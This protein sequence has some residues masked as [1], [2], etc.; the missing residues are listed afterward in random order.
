MSKALSE[1]TPLPPH[2][3]LWSAQRGALR[4]TAV[5]LRDGSLCLYSPVLGLGD[6]A[7][8]SLDALG[9][10]SVLLA[11]NHYH[12][13][14]L[15]EYAQVFPDA[16]LICSERA[17][18]RLEKQTGL[19]FASLSNLVPLLPDDCELVEPDGL[20]TGEVWLCTIH[21]NA[22]V[23]IVCDA[24]KGPDGKPGSTSENIE[25]L[26]TFPTYGVKN[27]AIYSTWVKTWLET[28]KPTLVAPCHGSLVS[29][30]ELAF[31]IIRL[32]DE[33][34]GNAV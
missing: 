27:K 2:P 24:F 15:T 19:S 6:R 18:P 32:I 26:R 16:A 22:Q 33:H 10:V 3:G 30:P 4:C 12:N 7:R 34:F 8:N 14:G 23:W 9:K 13:K 1:F 5:R 21:S 28:A 20:K 17:M 25:L 29:G 11:P 31:D